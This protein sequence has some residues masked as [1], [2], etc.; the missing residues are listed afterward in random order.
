MNHVAHDTVLFNLHDLILL[1][2]AAQYVL[3]A[4]LLFF[5]RKET[6]KSS[7]LLA[8]ILVLN[9]LHSI[10]TLIIWSD[11]L[12]QLVL[13]WHPSLFFW[14]GIGFWLQG[15]LLYWYV[16]SVLYK[17]FRLKIFDALHLIPAA[18]VAV[19][20]ITFY[21]A[22]PNTVQAQSMH[23]LEFMWTNMMNKMVTLRYVSVIIY[24]GWCLLALSH[25]RKQLRHQYANLD[26]SERG[27]L[28]WVVLGVAILS[29][30]SL[31]VH[32]IGNSISHSVSNAMGLGGNYFEFIFVNSLVFTSIRYTHL[33]DGL[34]YQNINDYPSP[35][36]LGSAKTSSSPTPTEDKGFKEE[37]VRR[38]EK[39]MAE[40]KPHLNN[41][42]NLE[43]L[44]QRLSL[45]ERTLSRIV[46]QHFQKNFFEFINTHRI[47]EAKSLLI[48]DPK[49]TILDVLAEAGFSS[50]STFNSIFKQQVGLTP[51]QFRLAS[52]KTESN[53]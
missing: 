21:H 37:Q 1:M 32:L 3:L 10:D 22:L 47:E 42:I 14:G 17:D 46:N 5:T 53:K 28:T 36:E 15:P 31:V 27:W 25:Y 52:A 50:K 38:L 16:S 19:L 35:N 9:A 45:P 26:V 30:W 24:G 2:A 34:S 13:N 33:F 18:I 12:R 20:L 11:E 23:N 4:V 8:A 41:D 6:E 29:L 44:A 48:S 40:Q 49:K 39:Y 7:Y 51:T 43:T